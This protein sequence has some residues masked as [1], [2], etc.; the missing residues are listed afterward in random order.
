MTNVGA[1]GAGAAAGARLIC[2]SALYSEKC[3]CAE[4]HRPSPQE[5][6]WL[7]YELG[8]AVDQHR[9]CRGRAAC[10]APEQVT[11]VD[12]GVYEMLEMTNEIAS[13][14]ST[15]DDT[16][17]FVQA[18]RQMAGETLRRD[19]LRLVVKGRTTI[20]EAMRISNQFED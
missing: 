6:E 15:V 13:R 17:S 4:A 20:E 19:A 7:R 1:T 5:H 12:T 11:R 9:G 18:A 3:N 2:E 16:G 14:P 8:D 10:I